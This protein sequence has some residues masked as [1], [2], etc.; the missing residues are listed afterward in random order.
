MVEA[1]QGEDASLCPGEGCL[2]FSPQG[3]ENNVPM[4]V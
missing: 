4:K 2:G 3:I 1:S